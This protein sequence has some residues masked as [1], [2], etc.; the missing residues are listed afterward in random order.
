MALPNAKPAPTVPAPAT[1]PKT[2]EEAISAL[3]KN[4][5]MDNPYSNGPVGE[6]TTNAK[7]RLRLAHRFETERGKLEAAEQKAHGVSGFYGRVPSVID[8]L[9]KML[10]KN[11]DGSFSVEGLASMAETA[12]VAANPERKVSKGSSLLYSGEVVEALRLLGFLSYDPQGDVFRFTPALK[13][14]LSPSPVKG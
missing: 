14:A 13:V 10:A 2:F 6:S 8:G 5:T 4:R 7:N 9:R 3:S 12:F 1:S 11:P